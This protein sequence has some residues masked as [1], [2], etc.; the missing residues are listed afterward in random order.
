MGSSFQLVFL[1][2]NVTRNNVKLHSKLWGEKKKSKPEAKH[3]LPILCASVC[4]LG[5]GEDGD[6]ITITLFSEARISS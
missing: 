5:K 1:D 6:I 2:V 3:R 4:G